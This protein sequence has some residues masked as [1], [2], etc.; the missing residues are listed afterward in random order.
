MFFLWSITTTRRTSRCL[1]FC[2]FGEELKVLLALV[3]GLEDGQV[4]QSLINN[5]EE[6]NGYKIELRVEMSE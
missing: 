4:F 2:K 1:L 5:Q 6:T 3:T